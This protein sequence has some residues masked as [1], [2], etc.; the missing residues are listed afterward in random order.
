MTGWGDAA[1]AF[2]AETIELLKGRWPQLTLFT[3]VSHLSLYVVLLVSLRHIGVS[4]DEVG[5]AEILAAF[6]FVR[7][8]TALPITPGGAGVV[9]LALTAALVVAGGDRGLVVAAVLVFRS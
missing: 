2:R 6:A 9:E 8:L 5:W 3:V 7:L 4:E 1:V